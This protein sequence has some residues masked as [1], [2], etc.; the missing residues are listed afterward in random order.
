MS[1]KICHVETGYSECPT[2][3]KRSVCDPGTARAFHRCS[4]LAAP[5]APPAPPAPPPMYAAAAAGLN[6]IAL[7]RQTFEADKALLCTYVNALVLSQDARDLLLQAIGKIKEDGDGKEEKVASI[8]PFSKSVIKAAIPV[9]QDLQT[10]VQNLNVLIRFWV[11][12][13][14][15]EKSKPRWDKKTNKEVLDDNANFLVELRYDPTSKGVYQTNVHV[16]WK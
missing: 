14:K 5:K 12:N 7:R 11:M 2:G 9:W 1:S 10:R 6:A 15:L 16:R 13:G 8:G 4:L 3:S